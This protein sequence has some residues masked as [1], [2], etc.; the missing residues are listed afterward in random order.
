MIMT[1]CWSDASFPIHVTE[2]VL[3]VSSQS[4]TYQVTTKHSLQLCCIA[5]MSKSCEVH[6][7]WITCVNDGVM[8]LCVMAHNIAERD[9]PAR[10]SHVLDISDRF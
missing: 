7:T 10:H 6:F 2:N 9:P 3:Q 8:A 5:T 1:F 4:Q